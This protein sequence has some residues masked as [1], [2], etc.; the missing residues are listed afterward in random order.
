MIV[1][2]INYAH[3]CQCTPHMYHDVMHIPAV[4]MISLSLSL[5]LSLFRSLGP[6]DQT[7]LDRSERASLASTEAS[8]T[9]G[10]NAPGEVP[11]GNLIQF[12]V[13]GNI[14]VG[15]HVYE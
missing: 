8:T 6:T 2:Y 15:I 1:L 14:H 12:D 4:V 9:S 13:T 11:T 7:S 10:E 3:M 5:S